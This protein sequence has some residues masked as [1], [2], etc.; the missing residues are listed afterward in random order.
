MKKFLLFT[1]LLFLFSSTTLAYIPRAKTIIKKMARNNGR[2]SYTLV[3]EVVLQSPTNQIKAKETWTVAH[4]DKMKLVVKSLDTE[5]PWTFS[6]VYDKSKRQTLSA[7]K[8]LKSFKKSPEFFE[9]LF[10]DRSYRSLTLRLI[11]H[12]FIPEWIKTAP[13]PDYNNGKTKMTEEPF[14]RLAP[15]EGS[16]SYALGASKNTAGD[17]NRTTLWVEQDS[18]YIKKGRLRSKAEFTNG[19]FQSFSGGLK[20]P[21]E[22]TIS[23][24]SNVARIKLMAVETIKAKATT[25]KLNPK[26]SGSIPTDPL[27]KE[28]YSRFR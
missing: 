22:Q 5:R 1:S 26:E 2:R 8:K 9:P 28:F 21:G 10:H 27:I 4:G 17:N 12:K 3:R 25:W 7:S 20:L 6:I 14:I 18:F 16:I 11:S 13:E 24:G 23:W 19:A 15:I